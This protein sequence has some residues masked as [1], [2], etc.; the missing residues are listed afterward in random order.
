MEKN[1]EENKFKSIKVLV[2]MYLPV[3]AM[4]NTSV[5]VAGVSPIKLF[6][7]ENAK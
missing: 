1:V 5:I 4:F 6:P 7:K 2:R 3:K